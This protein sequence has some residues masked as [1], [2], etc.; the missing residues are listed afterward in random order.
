MIDD[1]FLNEDGFLLF[2][3]FGL[4]PPPVRIPNLPLP[5]KLV[6]VWVIAEPP[7]LA[8]PNFGINYPL[9]V[10]LERSEETADLPLLTVDFAEVFTL[11][12]VL[13]TRSAADFLF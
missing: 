6:L 13:E 4:L 3:D 5:V 8:L 1:G 11:R 12:R 7:Y 9:F 2:T 10:N